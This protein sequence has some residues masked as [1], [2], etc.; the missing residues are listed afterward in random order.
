MSDL[1]TRKT[2]ALIILVVVA[3]AA[4]RC[5]PHAYN[6]TPI[7]AFALFCGA[8]LTDK[9]LLIL[10]LIALLIGD[11]INGFYSIVVMAFVYLGFLSSGLIGRRILGQQRTPA[12]FVIGTLSGA[13]SFYLLSN[14]GMWWA[15]YPLTAE[16]LLQ[17]WTDGL[18]FLLRSITGDFLYGIVIFGIVEGYQRYI[19]KPRQR[20]YE[21]LR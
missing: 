6:F 19:D 18:P 1:T 13:V 20:T 2:T 15:A 3:V 7:G 9:R 5:I 16:G 14:V 8:Y 17:C 4:A 10:P 11:A 12:R 21:Q